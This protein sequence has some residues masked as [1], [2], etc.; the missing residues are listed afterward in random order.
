MAQTIIMMLP[1]QNHT[2]SI[3]FFAATGR[4]IPGEQ[5]PGVPVPHIIS[6][7]KLDLG[8]VLVDKAEPTK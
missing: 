7:T 1:V 2:P 4:A 3:I 8:G 6:N 5:D